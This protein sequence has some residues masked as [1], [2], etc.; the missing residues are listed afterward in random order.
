MSGLVLGIRVASRGEVRQASMTPAAADPAR[1]AVA[2]VGVRQH[3]G[4][5]F[6]L[7]GS[8]AEA[9]ADSMP[10]PGPVLSLVRASRSP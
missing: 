8:P 9:V 4:Y 7:G 3:A 10:V 2:R 6:V 5:S 1:R